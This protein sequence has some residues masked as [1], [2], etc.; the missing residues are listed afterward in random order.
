MHSG[1]PYI[2][3]KPEKES[4]GNGR[5]FRIIVHMEPGQQIFLEDYVRETLLTLLSE[6]SASSRHG[7]LNQLDYGEDWSDIIIGNDDGTIAMER[8]FLMPSRIF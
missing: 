3:V 5:N 4:A 2:V 6:F 7:A 1:P 8:V